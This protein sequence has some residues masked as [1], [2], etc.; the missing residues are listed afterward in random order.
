MPNKIR[1]L[2]KIDGK[3]R[4]SMFGFHDGVLAVQLHF[5]IKYASGKNSGSNAHDASYQLKFTMS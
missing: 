5:K 1:V 4:S 3:S 2:Y